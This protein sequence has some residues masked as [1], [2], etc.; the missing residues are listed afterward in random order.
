M[1][2]RPMQRRVV[3]RLEEL[4]ECGSWLPPLEYPVVAA[5]GLRGAASLAAALEEGVTAHPLRS[6]QRREHRRQ[7]TR[8]DQNPFSGIVSNCFL[9]NAMNWSASDPSTMR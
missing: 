1:L 2:E 5:D 4:D 9:M 6:V 8:H 7:D 3:T